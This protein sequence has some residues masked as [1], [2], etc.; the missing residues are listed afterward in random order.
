LEKEGDDLK[1]SNQY[2][3][4]IAAYAGIEQPSAAVWVKRGSLTSRSMT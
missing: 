3:A 4:A 2:Q 1:R